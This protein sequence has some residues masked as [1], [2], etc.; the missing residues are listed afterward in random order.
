MGKLDEALADA[1][2]CI[3]LDPA[4]PKG[5]YRRGIVL[6]ASNDMVLRFFTHPHE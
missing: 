1:D 3:E 4:F 5:Y 2:K 6:K